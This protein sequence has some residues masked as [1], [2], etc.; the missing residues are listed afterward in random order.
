MKA[1]WLFRVSFFSVLCSLL[2]LNTANAKELK[3]L[4]PFGEYTQ[5]SSYSISYEDID[6]VFKATVMNT[7]MSTRAKA[8]KAQA[9]I[10]SRI[11]VNVKRLTALEGNRFFFETF[12][13]DEQK[14]IL[15]NIRKSL[16]SLPTSASLKHFSKAEQLAYWL[17]LYNI[18]VLDELVKIYPEKD[19]E[20]FMED[21]VEEKIL[22]VEGVKLSLNDIQ[23]KILMPKFD[24]DPLIIYGLYQGYIGGPNIRRS[25]Y[26]GKNVFKNLKDNAYEFVNSNRGTYAGKKNVFRA[27]SLYDRNEDFFPNFKRDLREHLYTYLV[28]SMR[29]SLESSDKLR[30]NINNWEITDLYGTMRKNNSSAA[31]N[32]AALMDAGASTNKDL[33]DFLQG[34]GIFTQ[35]GISEMMLSKVEDFGRFSKEQ[36]AKLR[37]LNERRLID[38]GSVTVTDL[39]EGDEGDK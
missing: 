13:S 23:F 37:A 35:S 25:A 32:E 15:T 30:T 4:E 27:S 26:T 34:S 17:N 20:D 18:T 9:N 31:T 39:E 36:S 6:T 24:R 3:V 2:V 29:Y 38:P 11:K 1:K 14:Q 16:E 21:L 19:I 12:E 10:G 8:K 28:G 5:G 7:G 33:P 22:T